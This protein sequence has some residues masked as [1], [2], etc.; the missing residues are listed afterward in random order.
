MD[1][2]TLADLIIKE[3]KNKDIFNL[4]TFSDGEMKELLLKFNLIYEQAASNVIISS[5]P[6]GAKF[7]FIK[8][9]IGKLI[10][11]FTNQQTE[12][13]YNIMELIKM[14]QGLILENIKLFKELTSTKNG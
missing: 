10:R 9:V 5:V 7:K 8:R 11:T 4:T 14:Q 12:F 13:N 1:T 3:I 2:K 6:S